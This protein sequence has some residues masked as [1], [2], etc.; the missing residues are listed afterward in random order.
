MARHADKLELVVEEG[1]L[2]TM[3]VRIRG[4]GKSHYV[5][6][7]QGEWRCD[8]MGFQ[9]QK[10][11]RHVKAGNILLAFVVDALGHIGKREK[12]NWKT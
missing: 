6:W 8:C 12:E 2:E 1:K 4:G 9:T 5:Q 3:Q 10:V 11:C 7:L